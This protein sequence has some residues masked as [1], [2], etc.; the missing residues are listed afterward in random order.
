MITLVM[1]LQLVESSAASPPAQTRRLVEQLDEELE[2][3]ADQTATLESHYSQQE[4]ILNSGA[5]VD[6]ATLSS[7]QTDLNDR[8]QQVNSDLDRLADQQEQV[9]ARRT[10]IESQ[11]Q[12]RSTETDEIEQLQQQISEAQNDLED[13][14]TGN[15]VF[16]NPVPG[17]SKTPWL[18][19]F[20]EGQILAAEIGKTAPPQSFTDATGFLSW[21]QKQPKAKVQF[22]LLVKPNAIEDYHISFNTLK[23]AGFGVGVDVLTQDQEAVDLT[24]GAGKP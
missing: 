3:L 15:R 22:V 17:S 10:K 7:Q 16:F 6:A 11:K 21:A 20:G 4:E 8:R 1:A 24:S 5:L 18:V 9:E 13:M 12:A 23:K 2:S 14:E 19:Q